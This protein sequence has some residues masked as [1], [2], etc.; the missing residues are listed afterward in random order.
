MAQLDT[1]VACTTRKRPG[2]SRMKKTV[3]RIDMTP[4][5]DLGFLLI[6]FFVITAELSRP[7]AMPLIM[8]KDSKNNPT[9][10]GDSYALTILLTGGKQYYYEGDWKKAVQENR[11]Q[12]TSL[13]GLREVI[14]R[15]QKRLDDTIRYKE[16]RKGLML[17]IKAAENASYTSVVDALDEVVINAVEKHAIIAISEEEKKWLRQRE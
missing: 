8:P 15:K 6:S 9:E 4:M 3:P 5:V 17:L 1:A 16:G 11:I 2:V 13:S 14:S 10:L 7:G 12:E